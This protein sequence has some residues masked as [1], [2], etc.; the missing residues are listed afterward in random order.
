MD[1]ILK[2][3][4]NELGM[5]SFDMIPN[6]PNV[7]NKLKIQNYKQVISSEQSTENTTNSKNI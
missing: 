1:F 2:K 6:N 5:P 3:I 7:I 4:D